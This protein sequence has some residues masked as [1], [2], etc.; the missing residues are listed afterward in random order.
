M[1]L[2]RWISFSRE[3]YSAHSLSS[4]GS[5][6]FQNHFFNHTDILIDPYRTA[7]LQIMEPA[8]GDLFVCIV[9]YTNSV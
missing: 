9:L 2:G 6:A 5:N 3:V 8:I 4:L 1:L 7:W